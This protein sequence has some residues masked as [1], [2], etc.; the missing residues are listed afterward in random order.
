MRGGESDFPIDSN[1][2]CGNIQDMPLKKRTYDCCS[3]G[4]SI[5]RD[6]NASLNISRLA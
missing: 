6:L 3:C 5:D 4:I 2:S 1:S